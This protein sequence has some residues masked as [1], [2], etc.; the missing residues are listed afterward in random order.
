MLDHVKRCRAWLDDEGEPYDWMFSCSVCGSVYV[1][2]GN[3]HH[4]RFEIL[5]RT[6][7]EHLSTHDGEPHPKATVTL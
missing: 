5:D 3:G 2:D 6:M 7:L 1:R 4:P